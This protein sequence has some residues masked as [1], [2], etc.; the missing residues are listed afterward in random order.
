MCNDE[1]AFERAGLLNRVLTLHRVFMHI[2]LESSAVVND[3]IAGLVH[4][5]T[6]KLRYTRHYDEGTSPTHHEGCAGYYSFSSMDF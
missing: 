1:W 2:C 6:W 3:L 4:D 5:K